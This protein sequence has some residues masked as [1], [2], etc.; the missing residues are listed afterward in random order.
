MSRPLLPL[1]VT[2]LKQTPVG[3]VT[4]AASERGLARISVGFPF[5]APSPP[6]SAPVWLRGALEQLA[7]YFDGR[8][9]VFDLPIDWAC[10][11]PTPFSNSALRACMQIPYGQTRT[12]AQLA[13]GLNA[14]NSSRA[15]GRA[16][17]TNPLPILIPCHRV[18]GTDGRLHGYAAPDGI[19]TKIRL[20]RLEG[21]TL[22]GSID[23]YSP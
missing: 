10:T 1:W 9:Q 7:E 18:V 22:P 20:L 2:I 13:A 15:V 8:R 17:D 6:G 12:Y 16:M 23:P 21:V 14:P 11:A 5:S 19:Q 4:L 3:P